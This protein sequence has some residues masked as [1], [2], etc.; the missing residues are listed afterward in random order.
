MPVMHSVMRAG[1]VDMSMPAAI[2][3]AR[4]V[5]VTLTEGRASRF[6]V[7]FAA[8]ACATVVIGLC[9]GWFAWRFSRVSIVASIAT[10]GMLQVQKEWLSVSNPAGF[11][12]PELGKLLTIAAAPVLWIG[13]S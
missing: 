5:T 8:I 3:F 11:A 13:S 1:E 2:P 7:A 12:P 6:P 4:M 9:H 10:A